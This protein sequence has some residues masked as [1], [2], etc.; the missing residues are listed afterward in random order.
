MAL[1]PRNRGVDPKTA[2]VVGGLLLGV[3]VPFTVPVELL[4]V[5]QV[6]KVIRRGRVERRRLSRRLL[7]AREAAPSAGS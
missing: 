1:I 6:E 5:V 2:R 4:G 7:S 3:S